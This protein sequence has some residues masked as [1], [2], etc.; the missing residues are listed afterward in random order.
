MVPTVTPHL[1]NRHYIL[2]D[3]ILREQLTP[4][5]LI[6]LVN[7]SSL[8]FIEAICFS[9]CDFTF[10]A[11]CPNMLSFEPPHSSLAMVYQC[12]SIRPHPPYTN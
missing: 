12:H 2:P 4:N 10:V 1:Y 3:K 5:S 8:P 11:P 6:G 7:V 9:L